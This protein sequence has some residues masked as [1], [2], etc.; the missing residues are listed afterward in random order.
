MHDQRLGM[1]PLEDFVSLRVVRQEEA[2]Q[3]RLVTPTGGT[4]MAKS[5]P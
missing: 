1:N 5:E 2:S 3:E 4:A